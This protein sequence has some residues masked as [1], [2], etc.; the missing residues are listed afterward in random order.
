MDDRELAAR[1]RAREPEAF[2]VLMQDYV[3]KMLRYATRLHRYFRTPEPEQAAEDTVQ[4]LL[5]K[6]ATDHPPKITGPVRAFVLRSI[7]N[8]VVDADRLRKKQLGMHP[9][10]PGGIAAPDR[11][12]RGALVEKNE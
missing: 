11:R 10:A 4:E 1:L 3:P 5:G 2:S 9:R 12:F 6:W 8:A 7:Y